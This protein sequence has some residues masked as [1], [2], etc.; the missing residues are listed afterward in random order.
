MEVTQQAFSQSVFHLDHPTHAAEARR[1]AVR[2]AEEI[3]MSESETGAVAIAVTEIAGNV[4]KH[5]E[6]GKIVFEHI[7]HDGRNGMRVLALDK[8]PGIADVTAALQDGFSTAGTN[9]NGLGAVRRL[10][11]YFDLYSIVGRGTCILAEFWQGKNLP[12]DGQPLGV[13]AIS[14]AVRG[15]SVCGD[16][17]AI[18]RNASGAWFMVVDGLGHGSFAADAARE[19]ER[20][21]AESGSESPAIILNDIHDALKKTRG[22][23]AGIAYVNQE[24]Q[25]LCFAGLGNISATLATAQTSRGIASHNG[26][27]GHQM[28][29]IQEFNLP[30]N[31]DSVLIMHSDGLSSRWDLSASRGILRRHPSLIAGVLYRDFAKERDDVTVLVAR[32]C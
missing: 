15:E 10:A 3:G 19:A 24:K 2:Q 8:G 16:G 27:L 12:A 17:W 11:T 5:A 7:H 1:F 25:T 13:G 23:A 6:S 14:I 32:N 21:F 4:V 29:R 31:E 28:Y 18:R 30:W 22:A 26:T 9:G 20:V